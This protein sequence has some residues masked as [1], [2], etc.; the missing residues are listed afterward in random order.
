MCSCGR[1]FSFGSGLGLCLSPLISVFPQNPFRR[2][3]IGDTF[4]DMLSS[5]ELRKL[6]IK[7][8]GEHGR[9]NSGI[10]DRDSKSIERKRKKLGV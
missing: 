6:M 3:L 7:Q 1:L 2:Y 4:C 9:V 8:D 5:T 10:R